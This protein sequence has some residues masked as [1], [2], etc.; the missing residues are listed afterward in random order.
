MEKNKTGKYR[1]QAIG[2][3]VLVAMGIL[4]ALQIDNWNGERNAN[5]KMTTYLQNIKEDLVSD[6]IAIN[7]SI[8]NLQI[9]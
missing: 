8:Y 7:N 9:F 3:I 5:A 1:K 6:T 4:I 2:E